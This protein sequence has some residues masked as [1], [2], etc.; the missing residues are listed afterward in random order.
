MIESPNKAFFPFINQKK[1]NHLADVVK[2][3][4]LKTQ[5]YKRIHLWKLKAI[6]SEDTAAK[7]MSFISLPELIFCKHLPLI[8]PEKLRS[9]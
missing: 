4:D 7:L 8:A 1:F 9:T 2:S 3:I 6:I 5:F